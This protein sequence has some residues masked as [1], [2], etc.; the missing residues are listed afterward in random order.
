MS[1]SEQVIE[2]TGLYERS[3][4]PSLLELMLEAD[5]YP[6]NAD[7]CINPLTKQRLVPLHLLQADFH[8][9]PPIKPMGH[10]TAEVLLEMIAFNANRHFPIF[11][12]YPQLSKT[13]IVPEALR[14]VAFHADLVRK[15]EKALSLAMEALVCFMR[16]RGSMKARRCKSIAGNSSDM[17]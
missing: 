12:F 1:T 10:V 6:H 5:P 16:G 13:G 17:G 14:C 15:G 9:D 4:K 2:S 11:T 8:L 7:P 3:R